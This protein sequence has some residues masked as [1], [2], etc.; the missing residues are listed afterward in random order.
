VSLIHVQITQI[1]IKIF[2]LSNLT[3]KLSDLFEINMK[4]IQIN[5]VTNCASNDTVFVN[6]SIRAQ[7]YT[8][9]AKFNWKIQDLNTILIKSNNLTINVYDQ[10]YTLN[11]SN[12]DCCSV[13]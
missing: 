8:S 4:N 7:H 10:N 5:N 13:K 2:L 11:Q 1:F 12:E 9:V 3:N 6:F